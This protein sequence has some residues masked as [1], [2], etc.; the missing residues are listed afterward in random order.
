MQPFL[1]AVGYSGTY[2]SKKIEK[3]NCLPIKKTLNQCI[4]SVVFKYLYYKQCLHY[5]NEVFVKAP[6]SGS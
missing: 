1:S 3:I 4:N 2:I 6:K 5:L